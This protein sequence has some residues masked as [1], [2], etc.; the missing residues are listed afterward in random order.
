MALTAT[1]RVRLS[2]ER[3]RRLERLAERLGLTESDV[4]RYGLDLVERVERRRQNVEKLIDLIDGEEPPK[5]RFR[6]K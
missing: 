5:I 2:E 3:A 1:K 4:I 6:M